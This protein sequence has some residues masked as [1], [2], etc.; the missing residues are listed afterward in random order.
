MR[1]RDGGNLGSASSRARLRQRR[2][3][4][5]APQVRGCALGYRKGAT[6]GTWV[7]RVRDEEGEQHYHALGAADDLNDGGG[8]SYEQAVDRARAFFGVAAKTAGRHTVGKALDT[9]LDRLR[10]ENPESTVADAEA[11]IESIIRP[12][13]GNIPLTKL[14]KAKLLSWHATLSEGRAPETV[15]RIT[16]MLKAALNLARAHRWVSDDSSWRDIE[17]LKGGA[18]RKVH[19]S[20]SQCSDLLR[21]C[22][23]QAFQDF[24]RAAILTGARTGELAALQV[25]DFDAATGTVEIRQ[26]KTGARVVFLSEGAIE[27]F[28]EQTKGK[29]ADD[30]L[31]PRADGGPWGKNHHQRPFAAAVLAAQLPADTVF[32]SLRHTYISLALLAGV[33]IQVLAENAGTSVR[34]IERHYGKFLNRDRRAMFNRLPEIT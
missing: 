26:G 27:F 21:H 31:L 23:P 15:N 10:R 9:Y 32:Y 13:L 6:G 28:A 8:L 29:S 25:R 24:V 7:A 14:T 18:A 4:Y 22:K 34:M 5:W 12:E 19:L 33:N 2:E 30:L 20:A 16:T 1:I 17:R 3:P 11:R